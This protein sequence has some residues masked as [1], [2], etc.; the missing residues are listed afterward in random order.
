MHV[1]RARMCVHVC[2]LYGG[3]SMCV[4]SCHEIVVPVGR[5]HFVALTN[6]LAFSQLISLSI[7]KVLLEFNLLYK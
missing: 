1:Q 3:A 5:M 7:I 2:I 4:R 6:I